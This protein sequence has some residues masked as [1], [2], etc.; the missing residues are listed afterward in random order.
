MWLLL[1][2]FFNEYNNSPITYSVNKFNEIIKPFS[3]TDF[4]FNDN[5]VKKYFINIYNGKI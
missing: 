1:F 3:L 4:K 5:F 2:I